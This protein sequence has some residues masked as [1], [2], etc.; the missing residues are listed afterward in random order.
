GTSTITSYIES[1]AGVA[2]G[3]RTGLANVVTAA[4]M[5]GSL[6]AY[7]VVSMFGE[8]VVVPTTIIVNG[9]P[10]ASL[11]FYHPVLAPVLIIVGSLMMAS[12]CKI[13]WNDHAEAI[14]AFLCMVIMLFSLSIADGI[15][16]GFIAY[17]LLKLVTGKGREVPAV[18][19]VVALLALLRYV[20][21]PLA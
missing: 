21:R 4:L 15:A 10:V 18:V 19:Y 16:W 11:G 7:P 13:R 8:S 12:V 3:A 6:F 1:A 17:C 14:P 2:E 9:A 20:V 5:L